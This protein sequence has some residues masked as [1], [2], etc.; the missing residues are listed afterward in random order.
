MNRAWPVKIFGKSKYEAGT[1]YCREREDSD[2]SHK[3]EWP[4]AEHHPSRHDALER[5][6][7]SRVQGTKTSTTG[8][9]RPS[10]AVPLTTGPSR[11]L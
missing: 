11:K 7:A 4:Q 5:I 8:N 1:C 3:A 2:R 6:A 9:H 10:L